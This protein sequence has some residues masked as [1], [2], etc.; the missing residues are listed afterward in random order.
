[1]LALALLVF[2]HLQDRI[3]HVVFWLCV[4]LI[5]CVFV[6]LVET[7]R[8]NY[9]DLA[10]AKARASHDPITGLPNRSTLLADLH[11]LA[12]QPR[13]RRLLVLIELD[14]LQ[15]F[16]DSVGEAQGNEVVRQ[17]AARLIEFCEGAEGSPY[18]VDPTR[19]A[20]LGPDDGRVSG[21]LVIAAAAEAEGGVLIGRCYGEVAVPGEAN[22]PEAALQLAGQRVSTNKQRQHRS[23]R[24]QAHAVL[25]AVL[26]ARR[27][28]L[29]EHL[30]NVAF[31]A[32][33][34]SRRLG[35]DGDVVDDVFLAAELQDIGLLTV[36]EK[37]LE[38][39]GALAPSESAMIRAHTV[40][41]EQIVA[42][43]PGLAQVAP[44]IRSISERFD[45]SGVPD[46]LAGE[47]IPLGSRIIAVSVAFAAMTS[48]RPYRPTLD[49]EEALA[50]LR[51]CAGTQ[52]DP[53]VV[54]AMAA[55]L[56]DEAGVGADLGA[57]TAGTL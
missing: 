35:L 27:P 43:A 15:T 36:P 55:D 49:D 8:R 6:W 53:A 47:E 42:V 30:R 44:L 16:Y 11:W 52:F 48:P 7:A 34:V 14:G 25:M 29:R 37:V 3:N 32:I 19:F 40:A 9:L 57:V 41:G 56:A 21:D 51:R 54:E 31:R 23:A 1:V 4:G 22:Q 50:E 12:D 45:G 20:V 39:G 17:V 10:R 26:E 28:D 46:G 38:K 5:A 24:R 2:D 18:R 33:S 13:E